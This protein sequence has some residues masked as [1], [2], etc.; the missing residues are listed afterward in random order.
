MTVIVTAPILPLSQESLSANRRVAD[1]SQSNPM[2]SPLLFQLKV[3]S[4]RLLMNRATAAI[5]KIQGIG[6]IV[7][8]VRRV[9]PRPVGQQF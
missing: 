8:Y 9:S 2:R 3:D 4:V 5:G 6:G 7:T 1:I